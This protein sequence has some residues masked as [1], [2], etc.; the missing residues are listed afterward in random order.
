VAVADIDT[1][2][3]GRSSRVS[4]PSAP[5]TVTGKAPESELSA[6]AAPERE[7]KGRQ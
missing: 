4:S 2:V 6:A 7:E 3:S 1:M 5:V